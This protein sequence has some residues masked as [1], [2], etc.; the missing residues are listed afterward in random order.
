MKT[1]TLNIGTIKSLTHTAKA[2]I[3]MKIALFAA[4]LA[5]VNVVAFMQ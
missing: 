5:C 1:Q 4:I 3:V 2:D